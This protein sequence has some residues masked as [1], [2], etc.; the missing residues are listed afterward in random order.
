MLE[1]HDLGLKGRLLPLS[2]TFAAGQQ[3]HLLG[4]NGAGKSSLLCLLAGLINPDSGRVCWQGRELSEWGL[5]ALATRRCLLEQQ[6]VPAFSLT[7]ADSLRF[8]AGIDD[9]RALPA[10]LEEH[11]K[12]AQFFQQPL[13]QLSGGQLQRVN[14][15]RN[16]LQI[17]SAIQTGQGLILLDEPTQGLDLQHQHLLFQLATCLC[18]LG[19]TLVISHHQLEHAFNYAQQLLLLKNGKLVA[20][21]TPP[22]LADNT[23]AL[24]HTFDCHIQLIHNKNTGYLLHSFPR[25]R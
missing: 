10:L 24:S 9:C 13:N 6:A 7:V 25:A 15:A 20:A 12:I 17:W 21:D 23:S 14:I 4:A 11:L 3:V 5:L 1:C 8:Y 22:A 18:G 16:L 19:N 2:L